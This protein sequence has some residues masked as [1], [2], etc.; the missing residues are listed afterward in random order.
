MREDDFYFFLA[1]IFVETVQYGNA[2]KLCH[3]MGSVQGMDFLTEQVPAVAKLARDQGVS[4][5]DYDSVGKLAD[6]TVDE[7]SSGRCWTYQYC[8]Q[9]GWFQTPSPMH[10]MRSSQLVLD[11]WTEMCTRVFG[12]KVKVPDVGQVD[13]EFG[14]LNIKASK[15][16]FGN[17]HDDPWQWATMQEL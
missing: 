9:F 3:V 1:D 6:T 12:D 14:G 7:Y 2:V 16:F 13:V 8:S 5:P 11:Y 15:I 17:G 10:P 4:P